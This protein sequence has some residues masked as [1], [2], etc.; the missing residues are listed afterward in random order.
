MPINGGDR[1]LKWVISS[2]SA[3]LRTDFAATRT[4]VAEV[5]RVSQGVMRGL[6]TEFASLVRQV[7][8]VGPLLGNIT[9]ELLNVSTAQ[10]SVGAET[11]KVTAE[12]LKLN[13]ASKIFEEQLLRTFTGGSKRADDMRLL[14]QRLGVDIERGVRYPKEQFENFLRGFNT[15]QG[16]EDR[17]AFAA[18]VFGTKTATLLPI[19]E[20]RAVA[21]AEV[22][23]ANV[24]QAASDQA[25]AAGE[26]EVATSA[27]AATSAIETETVAA[28]GLVGTLALVAGGL[29]IVAAGGAAVT[30]VVFKA[31]ESWSEYG[32]SI[33]KAMQKTGQS[34]EQ[35]SVIKFATEELKR[36]NAGASISF[37]QVIRGV[38][39]FE[40][41]V[42]RS[43]TNP[44]RQAAKAL[45]A[46]RLSAQGLKDMT[47]DAA[48][49]TLMEH[50][51]GVKN[52]MDRD[53]AAAD[54]FGR[55]FQ[56]L[57]PIMDA[58]GKNFDETKARAEA[59]GYVFS[60]KSA[61]QAR[62]F[63]QTLKD[64]HLAGAGLAVAF[65]SQVGPEVTKAMQ[66]IMGAVTALRP[67][68]VLA[69][70]QIAG[71]IQANV[72]AVQLLVVAF[73]AIPATI[74]VVNQALGTAA[75]AFGDLG[76]TVKSAAEG[77]LLF[78]TGNYGGAAVMFG[79]AWKKASMVG[80]EAVAQFTTDFGKYRDELKKIATDVFTPTRLPEVSQGDTD[81][82]FPGKTKKEHKETEETKLNRRLKLLEDNAKKIQ[83]LYEEQIASE[84]K[85]YDERTISLQ[86]LSEN[87]KTVEDVRFKGLKNV[88][89]QEILLINASAV[90]QDLKAAKLADVDAK[91]AENRKQN[92][93]TLAAIDKN[94]HD[95]EQAALEQHLAKLVEIQTAGDRL[96]LQHIKKL[97][98]DQVITYAQAEQ[99]IEAIERLALIARRE[100]LEKEFAGA[101]R[102]KE[103]RQRILDDL[104]A[105]G[106][107]IAAFEAGTDTA[108]DEAQT[109]DAE[110]R[111]AN[112]EAIRRY[113]EEITR[114]TR[115]GEA[116]R[117]E[118]MRRAGA[119][120]QS[121]IRETYRLRRLSID[122]EFNARKADLEQEV[123]QLSINETLARQNAGKI[124]AIKDEIAA[125]E[126]LHGAR[127]RT[128]DDEEKTAQRNRRNIFVKTDRTPRDENGDVIENAN[129]GQS[130]VAG[131]KAS[132]TELKEIGMGAF[133]TLADGVGQ[134]VS[135]YVLL[136]EV[137]PHALRKLLAATLAQ[138]AQESAVKAIYWTAQGIVDLFWN[139]GRAAADFAGAAL[140]ASI[141]GV[142]AV[143]GRA[144]AGDLFKSGAGASGATASVAGGS[145]NPRNATFSYGGQLSTPSSSDTQP[146]SRANGV[147]QV[148]SELKEMQRRQMVLQGQTIE[149]LQA[150]KV[151][152]PEAFLA[153]GA[154]T[155]GGRRAIGTA[156]KKHSDE[157]PSFNR[158]LLTNLRVA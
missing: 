121:I 116:I 20:A 29:A 107:E 83:D 63:Q 76:A 39:R 31:S 99:Q 13:Q 126:R 60:G 57:I 4:Q 95:K 93:V 90:A 65:G 64:L 106:V 148:F 53:R 104:R 47:P 112:E 45:D 97:A 128:N 7:P 51:D 82:E 131:L 147:F 89:D 88:Y 12:T 92:T 66:A 120:E 5:S 58:L 113:Q 117:L 156:I 36:S 153:K 71:W 23:A 56:N 87:E 122:D 6:N 24:T 67:V 35:L 48:F 157:A 44:S 9:H 78:A 144:L 142:T 33:F 42:S 75:R 114:I 34:A 21:S 109:K 146:G 108:T 125:L 80:A 96:R 84:R 132:L 91:V 14:F 73:R 115:E 59:M 61:A 141:A 37:D 27:A 158:H 32:D 151:A 105:L 155:N 110:R 62:Q 133:S 3:A 136:G 2:D 118:A 46:L 86:E 123:K 54:L 94:Q 74:V 111:L 18:Q 119:S 130:A 68:I 17:A 152:D 100:K 1:E 19:L 140:F 15:I 137:G 139:P 103:L 127:V 30:A 8:V 25:V 28:T 22:S 52:R 149:A 77:L 102:N 49:R 26:G 85:A 81:I 70:Q 69:A 72:V 143:A 10:K 79:D 38:A 134:M 145:E 101:G 11:V 41:N 129:R 50:L 124:Q 135:N 40:A 150:W 16:A 98:D 154:D 138:I 43:V 55:D